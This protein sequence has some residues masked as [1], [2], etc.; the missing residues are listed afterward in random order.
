MASTVETE[1]LFRRARTRD[2]PSWRWDRAGDLLAWDEQPDALDD[3]PTRAAWRHRR[4]LS[5]P[6]DGPAAPVDP[7]DAALAAAHAVHENNGPE[8]WQVEAR[9]LAGTSIADIALRVGIKPAVVQAYCQIFFDVHGRLHAH[10]WIWLY[11][12]RVGLQGPANPTEGDVWRYAAASGGPAVLDVLVDDYLG[13]PDP[14]PPGR[15]ELADGIRT[16]VRFVCTPMSDK[17]AFARVLGQARQVLTA[18]AESFSLAD[19]RDIAVHFDALES[20]AKLQRAAEKP[21]RRRSVTGARGRPKA[22]SGTA[23]SKLMAGSRTRRRARPQCGG[24]GGVVPAWL[25]MRRGMT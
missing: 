25:K 4:G 3:E 22:G 1:D 20:A 7:H 17:K 19:L 24:A 9:S 14:D 15:H 18:R 10:D 11:G 6:A 8:R 13:L 12:V 16:L 5:P 23:T 2:G 21:R